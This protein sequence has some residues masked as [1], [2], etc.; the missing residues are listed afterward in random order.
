MTHKRTLVRAAA[1]AAMIA[2]LSGCRNYLAFGTAT[3]FGLDISQRS[4][5]QPEVTLGYQRAEIVSIP[6][7]PQ[8]AKNEPN[9]TDT[10]ASA[11]LD[12]T[13]TNDAYSV[14]GTF[15]VHYNP[16]LLQKDPDFNGRGL[17]IRQVFATGMA[18]QLAARDS[19]MARFFG[20]HATNIPTKLREKVVKDKPAPPPNTSTN[21]GVVK[22]NNP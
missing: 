17:V 10:G 4:D 21:S 20:L 13:A 7:N 8:R 19:N 6:T 11:P 2:A 22:P 18:A 16:S 5:Q 15:A 1:G 3:K 9:R 12:A 14:L